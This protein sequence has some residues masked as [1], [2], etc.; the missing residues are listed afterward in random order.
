MVTP[1]TKLNVLLKYL[2]KFH[3]DTVS[4]KRLRIFFFFFFFFKFNITSNK[5]GNLNKKNK[6][7]NK[8]KQ[9]KTKQ[10][11]KQKSETSNWTDSQKTNLLYSSIQ[12]KVMEFNT[13]N[14]TCDY[15]ENVQN[16]TDRQIADTLLYPSIGTLLVTT[17]MPIVFFVG[18]LGNVAFICLVIKQYEL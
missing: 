16:W 13:R 8:T 2:C 15:I 6:T 12:N 17:I 3:L 5:I 14:I 1:S 4:K 7:K 18:V 9:N 11:T 10:K